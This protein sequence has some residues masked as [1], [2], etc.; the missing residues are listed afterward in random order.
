MLKSIVYLI[1]S[2][3]NHEKRLQSSSYGG[4]GMVSASKQIRRIECS[5]NLGHVKSVS[6]C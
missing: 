6:V 3:F 1:V 2:L 4:F 5:Q